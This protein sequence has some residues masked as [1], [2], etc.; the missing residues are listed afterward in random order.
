MGQHTLQRRA[1]FIIEPWRRAGERAWASLRQSPAPPLP[2]VTL[3]SDTSM[4]PT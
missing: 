2:P 3:A 1:L 4:K